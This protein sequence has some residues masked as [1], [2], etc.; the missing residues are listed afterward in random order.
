ADAKLARLAF[1]L[2]FTRGSIRRWVTRFTTAWHH[3]AKC[4]KVFLP[5]DYLQLQEHFH[6]LK[7]WAMY[8]H[9]AHRASFPSIAETLRECFGLPLYNAQIH[10]FQ[11]LLAHHY[12]G[13]YQRLL[14]KIVA[15]NLAH[16]DETEVRLRR[17]GK[18]YVWVLTNLEEVVFLY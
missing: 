17:V 15:G 11:Q 12:Q 2:R 6:S 16:I 10:T 3:C 14:D 13:A 9:I 18:G 4:Q 7:S 1:D 5:G 8:E